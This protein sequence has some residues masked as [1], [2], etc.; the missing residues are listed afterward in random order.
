MPKPSIGAWLT[1]EQFASL[2][3]IPCRSARHALHRAAIGNPVKRWPVLV[4][5]VQGRG[6]R[7]GLR[8]EVALSSL[9]EAYKNPLSDPLE[10]LHHAPAI[11]ADA[12][13]AYRSIAANQGERMKARLTAIEDALAFPAGSR[14]RKAELER[15]V[16]K[17]GH[18]LRTLQRWIADL[19]R[20]GGDVG[21]LARRKPCNAGQKRV[22]VSRRFDRAFTAAGHPAELLP[23]LAARVDQLT[24]AAWASPA[25][26][27]GWKMVRRE[28]LTAFKRECRERE[29]T[30]PASAFYISRR[31]VQDAE[32][33]RVVDVYAND[34]K[35]FDDGK[36]RGRRDNSKLAPMAQIVMDVKPLD[37]LLIRPDGSPFCPRMIGFQDTGTHR[38]FR[39]FV[40]PPKGQDVRQEHVIEAFAAMVAHPEWGLPQQ[41]YMD[42][43]SE[44]GAMDM[45]RGGL[46]MIAPP[47]ART[48]VRAKP[49]AASSK[50]VESKFA[51]LD[52][53]VFSQ[54]EG[55]IGGNR[56]NQKVQTVGRPRSPYPGTFE[57]FVD[58]ANRRILDFES[59]EI[60]SGP[61]EGRSPAGIYADHVAAGWRPVAVDPAAIDAAFCKRESRRVKQGVISFQGERWVHPELPT[62]NGR[63]VTLAIPYRRGAWPL[64]DLPG[65]GWAYL[66]P[67][68]LHLPGD[69]AGAIESSRLQ[70]REVRA[71]AELRR[72]A[73]SIDL[74]ANRNDRVTALPTR[75]APA[76][77]IDVLM[78]SEAE[79]LA[80]AAEG[81]AQRL[82]SAPSA[83]ERRRARLMA[84]TEEL[85]AY[86][87]SKRG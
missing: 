77:L 16:R 87:A 31:R 1:C 70:R 26:R 60:G 41:L 73:G 5:A 11:V 58:E 72:A 12:P 45:I 27:A 79:A 56:T 32:H 76:P 80:S 53:F 71:V 19:E 34:R 20:E 55:W 28:I 24:K 40:F 3:D 86:L 44:F 15:A 61:F 25:Q 59:W 67:E 23:E 52:R 54:F 36:P 83:A 39:H 8:Y 51:V 85:E 10:P 14:E 81:A 65:L 78:S 82:L 49:Y 6:G 7:S 48:I 22:L 57:Q 13:L 75:A 64:V 17:Y 47:G 4:R 69:I 46:E 38:I 63:R 68:M 30:L 43:G 42:N 66:Q 21:A 62:V 35:R 9:P 29:I 50:P 74:A 18:S 2:V 33:Y 84:E 37:V